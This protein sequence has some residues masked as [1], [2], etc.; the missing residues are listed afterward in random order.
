M[1]VK[2]IRKHKATKINNKNSKMRRKTKKQTHNRK[3]Q[4]QSKTFKKTKYKRHYRSKQSGGNSSQTSSTNT[5]TT[6][7][8]V[9]APVFVPSSSTVYTRKK[10]QTDSLKSTSSENSTSKL[11]KLAKIAKNVL[12]S[13]SVSKKIIAD[14]VRLK[15]F[16]KFIDKCNREIAGTMVNIGGKLTTINKFEFT[17]EDFDSIAGCDNIQK[18]IAEYEKKLEKIMKPIPEFYE[19]DYRKKDYERKISDV[20]INTSINDMM[21]AAIDYINNHITQDVIDIRN[22]IIT[23]VVLVDYA[24]ISRLVMHNKK[25]MD[26]N[27]FTSILENKTQEMLD[28]IFVIITTPNISKSP[29]INKRNIKIAGVPCYATNDEE[30]HNV[31]GYNES[32]D[33]TLIALYDIYRKMTKNGREYNVKVMST[34]FFEWFTP[35]GV[36][37]SDMFYL[38]DKDVKITFENIRDVLVSK[39]SK[40]ITTKNNNVSK[41][42]SRPSIRRTPRQRT[43]LVI[44]DP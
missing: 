1:G 36:S 22:P 26:L 32:D 35:T 8:N 40:F 28:T 33:F 3:K 7:F 24:N 5:T 37:K 29:L 14:G 19:Y 11:N 17:S 44:E 25:P 34:D 4:S 16:S 10:S 12:A 15:Q 38:A 41:S 21:K 39:Y 9:N 20:G 30:C 42:S 18:C 23:N 27:L 43:P 13:K 2:D 31:H 6:V